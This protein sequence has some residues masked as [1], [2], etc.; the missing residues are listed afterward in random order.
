MEHPPHHLL[1]LLSGGKPCPSCLRVCVW[2][3]NTQ[4]ILFVL[5]SIFY[6]VPFTFFSSLFVFF[7]FFCSFLDIFTFLHCKL[8][9]C[10]KNAKTKVEYTKCERKIYEFLLF[11][12]ESNWEIFFWNSEKKNINQFQ[13]PTQRFYIV[14]FSFSFC[15]F[16]R[17]EKQKTLPTTTKGLSLCICVS[18]VFPI[19]HRLRYIVPWK[20]L[21]CCTF[22]SNLRTFFPLAFSETFFFQNGAGKTARDVERVGS[23]PGGPTLTICSLQV[24][25]LVSKNTHQI[26]F[27][28]C[29]IGLF[30]EL[31]TCQNWTLRTKSLWSPE[32]VQV[33]QVYYKMWK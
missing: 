28:D 1:L 20:R 23:S 17:F 5:I 10:I 6:L 11:C 27:A 25:W 7:Y 22:F 26:L 8:I 3:E 30:L 19:S 31:T 29:W 4:F 32:P 33:S 13:S 14:I 2:S 15:S 9:Y 21:S 16:Q 24:S 18:S 12:S